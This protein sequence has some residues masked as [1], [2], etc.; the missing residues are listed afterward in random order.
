MWLLCGVVGKG[1]MVS[2]C[3]AI[4]AFHQE[5]EFGFYWEATGLTLLVLK[6]CFGAFV[7]NKFKRTN[8]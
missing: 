8:L 5:K 7:E 6:S 3:Q 4:T 1:T 2:R